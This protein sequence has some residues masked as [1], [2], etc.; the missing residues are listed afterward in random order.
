MFAAENGHSGVAKV[1]LAHGADVNLLTRE[2]ETAFMRA[3]QQPYT[4]AVADLLISHGADVYVRD[5][6]IFVLRLPVVITFAHLIAV[7]K[8]SYL[9][10]WRRE[11]KLFGKKLLYGVHVVLPV[12]KS[13]DIFRLGLSKIRT[14]S[15]TMR[16]TRI[17]FS[18]SVRCLSLPAGALCC[19]KKF[20]EVTPVQIAL[21][22]Y[23]TK[24]VP[25]L[26]F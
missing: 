7:G 9:T 23:L 18:M 12:V 5:H 8:F 10:C 25:L 19:F 22:S 14:V 3:I 4:G 26:S 13:M 11:T 21:C 6:V 1:L 20:S 15:I 16:C 17:V 2:N 24:T